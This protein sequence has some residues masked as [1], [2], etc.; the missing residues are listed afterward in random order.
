MEGW[1][2]RAGRG[3]CTEWEPMSR[4]EAVW[5]QPTRARLNGAFPLT[6][7]PPPPM[8]SSS[9]TNTTGFAGHFSRSSSPVDEDEVPD[10]FTA[11]VVLFK[12]PDVLLFPEL[13]RLITS[14]L[15][16]SPS[17]PLKVL[18]D[19]TIPRH[20]KY[21][22]DHA[23]PSLL[24]FTIHAAQVSPYREWTKWRINV[25]LDPLSPCRR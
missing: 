12:G 21:L 10:E 11:S 19:V 24:K 13:V 16:A 8:A 2:S 9:R 20:T 17:T 3:W 5:G 25:S 14:Q 18:E 6:T 15:E 1:P 7:S 4:T 23:E 22:S